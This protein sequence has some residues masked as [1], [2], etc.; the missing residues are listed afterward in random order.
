MNAVVRVTNSLK[1]SYNKSARQIQ[2]TP[3]LAIFGFLTS[4]AIAI[5]LDKIQY[6]I[7][8]TSDGYPIVWAK[9][10]G[11]DVDIYMALKKNLPM[12]NFKT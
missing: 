1:N 7:I 10:S 2:I 8:I 9:N 4:V 3:G 6:N 12:L 5:P 11:K